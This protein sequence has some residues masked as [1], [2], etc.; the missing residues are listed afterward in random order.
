MQHSGSTRLTSTYVSIQYL[1]AIAALGVV[2]VHASPT[3]Y[4]LAIGNAG[5][6]IF[7]VLSGFLMW[8]ITEARPQSPLVFFKHRLIRIVPMYWFVTSLLVVGALAVPSAF[9][10]L[11]FDFSYAL[12]SY[13]FV[14]MRPPGSGGADPIWPVLVQGWTLNYEMLFYVVF[15]CCLLLKRQARLLTLGTVLVGAVIGGLF[16]RGTDA[17]LLSW[18]D[19]LMLEFFAGVLIAVSV[20]RGMLL[21]RSAGWSL[22][23]AS[24]I[25]LVALNVTDWVTLRLLVWGVPAALL[26]WGAIILERTGPIPQ[27]PWLRAIGDSSYSLYLTHGLALSVLG[28]VMSHTWPFLFIGMVAATITGLAFF[29]LVERPMISIAQRLMHR[30]RK[31][32]PPAN[33]A[34][35]RTA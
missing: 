14:P 20:Q 28:K 19:S 15:A 21:S 1:R 13:L 31:A 5:V 7:F 34:L 18:S 4:T 26:V 9:P 12:G 8:T 6:D 23:A 3:G 10:K 16:Y 29:H 33:D 11:K 35:R 22:V 17:I 27:W 25:L 30:E 2:A 32:A 24:L